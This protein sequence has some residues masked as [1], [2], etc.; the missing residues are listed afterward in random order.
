MRHGRVRLTLA[1]IA[2]LTG[3]LVAPPA[4]G[5]C[6][7]AV[8]R[9][10][11]I[12]DRAGA[13]V[14]RPRR[15][16]TSQLLRLSR[17]LE[18]FFSRAGHSEVERC[19]VDRLDEQPPAW[20][21]TVSFGIKFAEGMLS[22]KDNDFYFAGPIDCQYTC[23]RRDEQSVCTAVYEFDAFEVAR[24]KIVLE[25]TDLRIEL[26][27]QPVLST[28]VDTECIPTTARRHRPWSPRFSRDDAGG[29]VTEFLVGQDLRLNLLL[30]GQRRPPLLLEAALLRSGGPKELESQVMGDHENR[31]GRTAIRKRSGGSS[32]R[33]KITPIGASQ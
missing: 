30:E 18:V 23:R 31:F 6:N 17:E 9:G 12:P 5:A 2:A 26:T 14:I 16:D 13:L 33:L 28:S 20:F 22:L 8:C 1:G 27:P 24:A 7:P 4:F 15:L 29:Y 32:P 21:N 3:C 19:T 25:S 10:T 11:D